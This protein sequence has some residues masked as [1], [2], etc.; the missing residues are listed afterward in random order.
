MCYFL[1][2]STAT[3]PPPAPYGPQSFWT[4]VCHTHTHTTHTYI[5]I[6]NTWAWEVIADNGRTRSE[7]FTPVIYYYIDQHFSCFDKD[8]PY[9]DLLFWQGS[10][11]KVY[12]DR[13][14]WWGL[15]PP[16]LKISCFNRDYAPW[17]GVL[18]WGIFILLHTSFLLFF[19][20][21]IEYTRP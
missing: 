5:I 10:F 18:A 7:G 3:T 8:L 15:S 21:T 14:Y 9:T 17:V 13:E 16:A 19:F 4:N 20:Y 1:S 11:P 2:F 6:S 12:G